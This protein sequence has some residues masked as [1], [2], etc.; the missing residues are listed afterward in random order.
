MTYN[1]FQSGVSN[2]NTSFTVRCAEGL[3]YVPS[4][5]NV[6][7]LSS[8]INYF[9]SLGLASATGIT[10]D[11]LSL[12]SQAGTAAGTTLHINTTAGA[13]QAGSNTASTQ[14]RV[15]TLTF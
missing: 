8:G 12:V 3:A 1:S 11:S 4:I 13:G 5:N 9:T 10:A 14:A 7:G 15:V 2:G 6:V